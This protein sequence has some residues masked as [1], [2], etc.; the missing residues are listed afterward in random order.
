MDSLLIENLQLA[1]AKSEI[2]QNELALKIGVSKS[3]MSD[4]FRTGKLSATELYLL[5]D[6]FGVGV[7]WFYEEHLPEIQLKVA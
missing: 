6:I 7:S 5:A 1:K 2:S 4:I 3:K